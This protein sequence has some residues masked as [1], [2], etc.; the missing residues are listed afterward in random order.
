MSTVTKP[1]T[2]RTKPLDIVARE[3]V[4]INTLAACAKRLEP[5]TEEDAAWVV[6]QLRLLCPVQS[7]TP[8]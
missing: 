4:K 2:E 5:L 7:E 8:A 1:T 3:R 6:S